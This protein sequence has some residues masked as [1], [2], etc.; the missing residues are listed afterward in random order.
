MNQVQP[1]LRVGSM[2][3]DRR[4]SVRQRTHLPAF[5]TVGGKSKSLVLDLNEIRDISEAG[6]CFQ[7]PGQMAFGQDLDLSLDLSDAKAFIPLSG[8]VVWSDPSGRTGIRFLQVSGPGLIQLKEWLFMNAMAACAQRWEMHT[9]SEV[10]GARSGAGTQSA[11]LTAR[12]ETDAIEAAIARAVASVA[13]E[14]AQEGPNL[15]SALHGIAMRALKLTGATGAALAV[16]EGELFVCRARAGVDAPSVGAR[17]RPGDGFSGEC[18]RSGEVVRCEDSENDPR[19]DRESCRALGVRSIVAAPVR[20]GG[21]VIGLLEVFSSQPYAFSVNDG[22]FLLR[23]GDVI[24]AAEQRAIEAMAA[25]SR[26]SEA[27]QRFAEARA[28]EQSRASEGSGRGAPLAAD[29]REVRADAPT[30]EDFGESGQPSRRWFVGR[31]F[32]IFLATA[33]L[34]SGLMLVPFVRNRTGASA[35]T[36]P[37]AAVGPQEK[38][39][40]SNVTLAALNDPQALRQLAAQGDATAQFA[41][42]AHYATGD[43]VAQD[44][45]EAAKWFSEAAERGHVVAQATLGAYYWAGRGVEPDLKKAYF[46]SILA[47]AGGDQASKYR[48]AVLASRLSRGEL[49]AAQDD[50]N[51]WLRRHQSQQSR[52]RLVDR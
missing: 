10:N 35:H 50:A 5:A 52:S 2:A 41:L 44:Y 38:S 28:A 33:A 27:N 36:N 20:S 15:D 14:A 45:S 31:M 13:Q 40:A 25:R 32:V 26:L 42:G 23:L 22:N 19:V 49:V 48:V 1:A 9:P 37:P 47:Q 51:Q 12:T 29:L 46:W 11:P 43:G 16:S 24:L 30:A 3:H 6:M 17:L 4:A 39:A 8:R 7:G 34:L 18:L 21:A